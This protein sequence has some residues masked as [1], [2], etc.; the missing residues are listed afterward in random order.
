MSTN[1]NPE[2]TNSKEYLLQFLREG[3]ILYEKWC[4]TF[5]NVFWYEKIVFVNGTRILEKYPYGISAESAN[6]LEEFNRQ[7]KA[8][9]L[10]NTFSGLAK[11][12][13]LISD[14]DFMDDEI[15]DY[16]ILE[17]ED[18]DCLFPNSNT[19]PFADKDITFIKKYLQE[20]IVERNQKDRERNQKSKNQK[21]ST[22]SET[23]K[24]NLS[25]NPIDDNVSTNVEFI[26]EAIKNQIGNEEILKTKKNGNLGSKTHF[27][28]KDIKSKLTESEKHKLHKLME[29]YWVMIITDSLNILPEH[30]NQAKKRV[31]FVK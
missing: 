8:S 26:D 3:Y 24:E 13:K 2:C 6:S 7:L 28:S 22:P 12:F 30:K 18:I 16:F 19:V 21:Q 9:E 29:L 17:S 10:L 25:K 14:H 11:F 1:E 5:G 20:K 15:W 31:K 23:K 4:S 27:G